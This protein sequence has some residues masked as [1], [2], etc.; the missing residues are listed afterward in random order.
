MS[1][2][3]YIG[4]LDGEKMR[5]F[6]SRVEL[7]H[8]LSNKPEATFIRYSVKREPKLKMNLDEYELAPF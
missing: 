4:L 8:W 2:H 1:Q 3:R 6:H 5:G 7:E